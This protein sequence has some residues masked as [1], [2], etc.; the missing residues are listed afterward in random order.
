M[1]NGGVHGRELASV[2]S[3]R[4]TAMGTSSGFHQKSAQEC[5]GEHL[6]APHRGIR[7]GIVMIGAGS[8]IFM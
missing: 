8:H 1:D 5:C 4:L 3:A 6:A 2:P 7:D